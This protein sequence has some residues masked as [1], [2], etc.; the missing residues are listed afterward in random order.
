MEA[1]YVCRKLVNTDKQNKKLTVFLPPKD[2]NYNTLVY[3]FPD[4]IYIH[5]HIYASLYTHFWIII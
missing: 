2:Q 3:I 1:V 4:I 5:T